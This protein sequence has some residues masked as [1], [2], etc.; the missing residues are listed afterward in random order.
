MAA[1]KRSWNVSVESGKEGNVR[2]SEDGDECARGRR[3]GRK[4]HQGT[5][6]VTVRTASQVKRRQG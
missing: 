5:A 6:T 4:I 3:D 2:V 1:S